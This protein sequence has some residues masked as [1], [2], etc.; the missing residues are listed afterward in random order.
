VT[1]PRLLALRALGL[2]DFLTG[3]PA[4]RALRRAAP[5]HELWLAAPPVLTPLVELADCV[6]A[7]VPTQEL[8]PVPWHGPPPEIAVDLHGNGPPTKELLLRLGPARLVAFAGPHGCGGWHAGPAWRR[9][10]H[11]RRRWCRLVTEEFAVTADPDDVRIAAPAA[12]PPRRDAVVI[13][14]GAASGSRRWPPERWVAVAREL[15]R[16]GHDVVLT[17]GPGEQPLVDAVRRA[18]GLVRD[19][20][21]V[22]RSLGELA[23]LIACARL[24][25]CGDTGIAHLATALGVPSVLLFG[26]TP[27]AWWGPPAGPHRVL[28]HGTAPGDPHAADP[29][30]ALLRISVP[31]VLTAISDQLALGGDHAPQPLGQ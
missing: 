22:D 7:V 8:Q 13:H 31:E 4:L 18:A 28:W 16:T 30:P 24:V 5:E 9:D 12:T 10:E 11:E 21:A 26:P 14:P 25:A 19:A 29:D 3:V 1:R 6:D 20:T 27:P 15:T 2:G 17:G 23:G